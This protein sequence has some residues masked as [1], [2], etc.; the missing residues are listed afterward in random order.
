[1]K[2]KFH[3]GPNRQA[4]MS[5]IR[6]DVAFLREVQTMDYSLLC[7]I[8]YPRREQPAEDAR[9]VP[10]GVAIPLSR[11]SPSTVPPPAATPRDGPNVA[12]AARPAEP[13]IGESGCASSASSPACSSL[14][15]VRRD[16]SA[17][18][19]PLRNPALNGSLSGW[20]CKSQRAAWEH[21][22]DGAVEGNR[23]DGAEPELYFIGIIDILTSWSPAK[24][25]ENLAKKIMN[26]REASGISAVPPDFYAD[27]FEKALETWIA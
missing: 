12:E 26:P 16:V 25:V 5:Q 8:H 17:D 2:R 19:L 20:P 3:F 21:F 18:V 10:G 4:L 23:P 22:P 1:M 13:A 11:L 14:T 9:S 15:T 24:T 7:G 27:R 6:A